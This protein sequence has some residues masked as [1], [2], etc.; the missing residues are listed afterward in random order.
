LNISE[1]WKD[2]LL[3]LFILIAVATDAVILNRLR[4]LWAGGELQLRAPAEEE[5][6]HVA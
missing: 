3:G 4:R 6:H 1:F 2:A 5:T